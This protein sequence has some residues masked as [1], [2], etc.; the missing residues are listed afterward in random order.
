MACGVI[1]GIGAVVNAAKIKPG[2]DVIVIGAGGV[3]LNAI[4]G[5]RL[6]GARRIIA[7]LLYTSPSP[8]AS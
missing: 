3:G 5:A 8:R 7:C 1:T 2:Q 6:A 4:Q